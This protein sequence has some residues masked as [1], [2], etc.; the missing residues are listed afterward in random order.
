M[1]EEGLPRFSHRLFR[2]FL[3]YLR[4]YVRKHFTAVRLARGTRPAPDPGRPLVVYSNHPSWWDPLVYMWLT[5]A[6]FAGREGYGPM[7]AAA[8]RKYGFFRRL[9]VFGVET[10][11]RRGA[12]QFLRAARAVLARPGAILCS[13]S[14]TRSGTSACPRCWCASGTRFTSKPAPGTT[15]MPGRRC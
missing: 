8:L 7:D 12:A 14:S 4:R 13:P 5:G 2:G 1:G 10:G 6:I 15:W 9:G 3:R 11:N